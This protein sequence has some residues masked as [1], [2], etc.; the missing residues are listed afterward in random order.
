MRIKTL[1]A[2]FATLVLSGIAYSIW[3]WGN[4]VSLQVRLLEKLDTNQGSDVRGALILPN[5]QA[6]LSEATATMTVP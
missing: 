4:P 5:R 6:D 1:L 3:F 2:V